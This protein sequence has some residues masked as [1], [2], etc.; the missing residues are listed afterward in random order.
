MMKAKTYLGTSVVF[1]F[2][3]IGSFMWGSLTFKAPAAET[4]AQET[5]IVVNLERIIQLDAPS[6]FSLT[7]PVSNG[8][9]TLD[10]QSINV[11]TNNPTGYKLYA[12]LNPDLACLRHAAA[13][14]ASDDCTT[15]DE[16]KKLLLNTVASST[17]PWNQW[18]MSIDS[19]SNWLAFNQTVFD[20][21]TIAFTAYCGSLDVP[22]NMVTANG[23]PMSDYN[24]DACKFMAELW[25]GVAP[26]GFL[27]W[28]NIIYGSFNPDP[29]PDFGTEEEEGFDW[30]IDTFNLAIADMCLPGNSLATGEPDFCTSFVPLEHDNVIR[31]FNG[32]SMGINYLL[33]S[34]STDIMDDAFDLTVGTR[35]DMSMIAGI[36]TT[37]MRITALAE[38]TPEPWLGSMQFLINEYSPEGVYCSGPHT[39]YWGSAYEDCTLFYDSVNIN[40]LDAI[41]APAWDPGTGTHRTVIACSREAGNMHIID[42]H[43]VVCDFYDSAE[44]FENL[45]DNNCGGGPGWISIWGTFMPPDIGPFCAEPEPTINDIWRVSDALYLNW[46][47]TLPTLSM[48]GMFCSGSTVENNGDTYYPGCAVLTGVNMDTLVAISSD[49]LESSVLVNQEVCGTLDGTLSIIDSRTV[50]CDYDSKSWQAEIGLCFTSLGWES[51]WG[52]I[53]P[54][55]YGFTAFTDIDKNSCF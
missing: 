38:P 21:D 7:P 14:L 31:E 20:Y 51:K 17:L 46:Y 2:C 37:D 29:A 10:T 44:V 40:Y 23:V 35:V 39:A 32:L 34:N 25:W 13:I 1:L 49:Q 9:P 33:H 42:A 53:I 52:R 27:D 48:Y 3:F 30:F 24:I 28:F 26:G 50:V 47:D 11:S 12:E 18:G 16:D 54:P 43:T 41:L 36:Y 5:D 19:G 55:A 45:A 15:A 4:S 6:F 8:D 22:I